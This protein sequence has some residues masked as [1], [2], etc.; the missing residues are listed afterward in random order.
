MELKQK[1]WRNILASIAKNVS[2]G[3]KYALQYYCDFVKV[4]IIKKLFELAQFYL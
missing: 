4:K 3:V 1:W 2:L